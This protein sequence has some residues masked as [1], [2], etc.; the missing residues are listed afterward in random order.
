MIDGLMDKSNLFISLREGQ[1]RLE[2][3][4]ARATRASCLRLISYVRATIRVCMTWF[5]HVSMASAV[6]KKYEISSL[7]RMRRIDVEWMIKTSRNTILNNQRIKN[8]K[9]TRKWSEMLEIR[10]CNK[11]QHP[12]L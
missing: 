12:A 4:G 8:I 10:N 7:I 6:I 9:K 1:N 3:L 5:Q 11:K 2:H